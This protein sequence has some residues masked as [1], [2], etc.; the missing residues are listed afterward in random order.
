MAEGLDWINDEENLSGE[1]LQNEEDSSLGYILKPV[2]ET[3][4][5]NNNLSCLA[6]SQEYLFIATRKNEIIRKKLSTDENHEILCIPGRSSAEE[7]K[8]YTDIMGFHCVIV[9]SKREAF[10]L[11]CFGKEVIPLLCLKEFDITALCFS[12]NAS[13]QD[14]G[15]ILIGT[16]DGFILQYR[17][18][19]NKKQE[20]VEP[21]TA[22]KI[23]QLPNSSA[24]YGLAFE[25]YRCATKSEEKITLNTLV[26]A[27]TNDTCYQFVGP[28][29]FEKLFKKY[30]S[31]E[32]VN[33][34]K[35][36]VSKG[37]IDRSE[38][39]VCYLYKSKSVYELHSFAWKCG[40]GICYAKFREKE[41][42]KSKII[43]KDIS[44]SFYQKKGATKESEIGIP[45]AI[46]ITEY[47]LCFLYKDSITII[48]KITKEIEFSETFLN[49]EV[50]KGIVYESSS[51]TIWLYSTKKLYRLTYSS[52]SQGIWKQHLESGSYQEALQL[53]K[54]NNPKYY[55]HVAGVYA[56][57][58][59]RCEKYIE[60][61]DLFASSD[62]K[63]E[64]VVLKYLHISENEG[65]ECKHYI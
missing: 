63:F 33:K 58:R 27:V 40:N 56:N 37:S 16:R 51:R 2:D 17:I 42:I 43:I 22:S 5:I 10:Y 19:V 23:F 48:S 38:F 14:T 34:Y 64:N 62:I 26:L 54:E 52:D 25:T 6:I 41:D 46:C 61:A 32:E 4:G 44:T 28:L 36:F 35:K 57:A 24:I 49:D 47:N 21:I 12:L 31:P 9:N 3:F 59:F 8:L 53:C 18:Q 55:R 15:D 7:Y 45:K 1:N 29:P 30:Q 65:L 60:A 11:H 20:I 13:K 39:Q 50:M